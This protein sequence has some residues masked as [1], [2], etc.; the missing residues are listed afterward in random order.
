MVNFILPKQQTTQPQETQKMLTKKAVLVI[1]LGFESNQASNDQIVKDIK[2]EA[3][4]PWCSKICK[5]EVYSDQ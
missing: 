1:E 5:I 4:I 3:Q 2:K